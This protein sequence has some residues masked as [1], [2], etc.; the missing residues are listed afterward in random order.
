[1]SAEAR[2]AVL[3][4]PTLAAIRDHVRDVLCAHDRLDANQAELR[5]AHIVRAG[6]ECGLMFQIRGPRLLRSYAIWAGAESRIL[7]YES[8]GV[9]FA[10]TKVVDG[11]EPTEALRTAA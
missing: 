8:T 10:E 3:P 9:R 5:Q 4:L 7:F 6:K 11:P 1:M 2:L